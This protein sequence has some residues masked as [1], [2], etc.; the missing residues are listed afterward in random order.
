MNKRK[1]IIPNSLKEYRKAAGYRQKDVARMIGLISEDRICHWEKGKNIPNLIN[2]FK[3]CSLY[4]ATPTQ[5]YGGL[6]REID[7]QTQSIRVSKN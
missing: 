4:H 3:L 1:D 6:Q 5:L 2:L 7:A